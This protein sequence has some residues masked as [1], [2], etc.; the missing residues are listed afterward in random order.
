MLSSLPCFSAVCWS[1]IHTSCYIFNVFIL[2]YFKPVLTATL[3]YMQDWVNVVTALLYTCSTFFVL[4]EA[5]KHVY[6]YRFML[7]FTDTVTT[8]EATL[9]AETTATTGIWIICIERVLVLILIIYFKPVLTATLYYVQDWVNVV[10]A[11]CTTYAQSL[12]LLGA[13]RACLGRAWVNCSCWSK[14]WLILRGQ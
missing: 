8:T 7:Y 6:H 14:H 5:H 1:A 2:V 13:C 10:T 3:Y 4:Y 9:T 12:F 11:C